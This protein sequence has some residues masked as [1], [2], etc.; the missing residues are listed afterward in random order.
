[1]AREQTEKKVEHLTSTGSID[2]HTDI[3]SIWQATSVRF[4]IERQTK[5]KKKKNL[6]PK[7]EPKAIWTFIHTL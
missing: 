2:Q 4:S 6:Y 1:M 7:L 5:K 3:Y